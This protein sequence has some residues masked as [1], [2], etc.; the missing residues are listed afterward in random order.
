MIVSLL[1][2]R[3]SDEAGLAQIMERYS[4]KVIALTRGANGSLLLRNSGERSDLAGQPVNVVDTV[5]AGDAFTAALALGI[6]R[7]LPLDD[8]NRWASDVA[9]FVC[10]QAGATPRLPASLCLPQ[11][12]LQ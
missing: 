6:L 11:E 3:G 4:L 1:Q 9:A 12:T 7:G 8:I 2:L 10:T 5:G